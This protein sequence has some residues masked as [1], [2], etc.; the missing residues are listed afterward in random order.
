MTAERGRRLPAVLIITGVLLL[1]GGLAL[2]VGLAVVDYGTAFAVVIGIVGAVLLVWLLRR[3]W[4]SPRRGLW[5]AAITVLLAV[6]VGGAALLNSFLVSPDF[7]GVG[8]EAAP[9]NMGGAAPPDFPQRD[10]DVTHY[11]ATI[12]RDDSQG[13]GEMVVT[14]EVIYEVYEGQ[15][16]IYADQRLV[17]P[18]R[19]LASEPRGFL[20][21]EVSFEPLENGPYQPVTFVLPDGMEIRASLCSFR[22]CP[23]AQV[24]IE[25]FPANAFF[26]ARGVSM[27]ESMP[28]L[29]TETVTWTPADLSDGITF[30]YVPAPYHYLSP[31]LRPFIGASTLDDW[32]VSVIAL[33]GT[34][35]AAP[36]VVP[37]LEYAAERAVGN[38]WRR[39]F[40]KR[41]STA[42]SGTGQ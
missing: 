32:M 1:A 13:E 34:L 22:S 12:R 31:V 6:G 33:L 9:D 35:V 25:D 5:I 14:E 41:R 23:P 15:T 28:Y 24:E 4:R 18:P 11:R 37:L 16:L 42:T 27:V 10:L 39:L 30:A 29:R 8:E 40:K 19:T 21:R 3:M 38:M 7:T 26:G 20:L 17:L 2:L 36:L